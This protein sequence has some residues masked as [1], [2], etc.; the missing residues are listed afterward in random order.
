MANASQQ[1]TKSIHEWWFG[2]FESITAHKYEQSLC[3]N[4]KSM[5]LWVEIHNIWLIYNPDYVCVS[6]ELA[7][8]YRYACT[9]HRW[10]A[11]APTIC[12]SYQIINKWS[13]INFRLIIFNKSKWLEIYH[14][15]WLWHITKAAKSHW[16]STKEWRSR[17]CSHHD[18]VK[19]MKKKQNFNIFLRTGFNWMLF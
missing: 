11:D 14:A 15:Q 13:C 2:M 3:F 17:K 6:C 19:R 7:P 4:G 5:H 18:S 1:I 12:R 16:Y 8:C 10:Y 9:S